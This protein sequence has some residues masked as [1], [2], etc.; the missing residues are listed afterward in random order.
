MC[1]RCRAAEV[2]INDETRFIRAA[3]PVWFV[4]IQLSVQLDQTSVCLSACA[5]CVTRFVCRVRPSFIDT[6]AKCEHNFRSDDCVASVS[7]RVVLLI[8]FSCSDEVFSR[9]WS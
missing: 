5:V 6:S 7:L 2:F 3:F 8:L 1:Y 4:D 9:L